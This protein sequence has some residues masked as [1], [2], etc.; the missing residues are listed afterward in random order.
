MVSPYR[1]ANILTLDP[2]DGLFRSPSGR[3]PLTEIIPET[4]GL[5]HFATSSCR[6][7]ECNPT[8]S[9]VKMKYRGVSPRWMESIQGT[10]IR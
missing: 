5:K 3:I 6:Q 10:Q 7:E 4:A 9:V 1:I 2:D 8:G